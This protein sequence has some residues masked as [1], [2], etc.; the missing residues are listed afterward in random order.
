MA[1]SL[2]LNAQTT[3]P[4]QGNSTDALKAHGENSGNGATIQMLVMS[5]SLVHKEL[6]R[7]HLL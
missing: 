7:R 4:G 3:F 1:A 2:N 6:E 5:L